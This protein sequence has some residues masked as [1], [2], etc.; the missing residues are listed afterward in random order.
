MRGDADGSLFETVDHTVTAAGGGLLREWITRPRR[1]RE[2][3]NRRLDAVEALASAALARDRLRDA[4]R[5]VRSRTA[6]GAGD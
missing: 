1:D 2:E 5:R 6:R 3:L 4:R